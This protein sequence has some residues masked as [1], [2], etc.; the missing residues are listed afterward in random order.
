MGSS[1]LKI[2]DLKAGYGKKWVLKNINMEVH[3]NKV[4]AIMGPS[5]CGK[6]TLIRC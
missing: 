6:S 5:G 1:I 4:T 3:K 2:R